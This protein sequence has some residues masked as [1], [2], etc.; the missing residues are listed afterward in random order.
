VFAAKRHLDDNLLIRRYLA[1]RG[2]AALEASDEAPLR[3]LAHCP[4]CEARYQALRTSFA[5]LSI[6]GMRPTYLASN[7]LADMR[8]TPAGP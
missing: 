3:H 5:Y 1:D 7:Q 6:F 4:A 2:L 8:L